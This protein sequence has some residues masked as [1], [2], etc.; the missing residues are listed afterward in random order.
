[1][2]EIDGSRG[3]G[4]GQLL[5]MAVALSAI[6]ATPIRVVHI[7]AGRPNPGLAP[8]HVAA[9]R[10][11]AQLCDGR[12]EGLRV[13]SAEI[14]FRPGPITS[15]IFSVE[16]GTAGSVALVFQACLA[17]AAAAPGTVRLRVSGGTDV[18]WSPPVD[19]LARVFLPLL[20]QIGGRVA[21][22]VL[23][24]G[25]YPRGGGIVEAVVEPTPTWRAVQVK[26]GPRLS[27]VRG[28]AHV[29]NLAD[30]IPK[31]M[32]HAA[33]RRLHGLPDVK[34]EERVYRNDEALGQGG[35]LVLWAEGETILGSASLAERGKPSER[36]G[37]EA[38]SH[39]RS[40]LESGAS[41]DVHAADQLLTY[42]AQA[43]TPSEFFVRE[44]SGHLRT[45]MSLLPEFLPSSIQ[46]VP[47]GK[48]WKVSVE[49]T[50]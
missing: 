37:E 46:A 19:Y 24:R 36:V 27:K 25:Y 32:K 12:V 8:Q 17:V 16:V 38:A 31:R 2:L 44:V 21:L 13:G 23:R 22:E 48:L 34:I 14:E 43:H 40:E 39:L 15:G 26:A 7:R 11:V 10:A 6:R 33:S 18:P 5:R 4:G 20:R 49:P 1:M 50:A 29:S 47:H 30:D 42:L 41:L 3:E 28:I 9:I 45:M 35:A